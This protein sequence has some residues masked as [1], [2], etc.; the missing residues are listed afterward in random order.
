VLPPIGGAAG[1]AGPAPERRK[2]SKFH[3]GTVKFRMKRELQPLHV[4]RPNTATRC[5][6]PARGR[7]VDKVIARIDADVLPEWLKQ[8]NG[9][10]KDLQAWWGVEGN[11]NGVGLAHFWLS[12][13]S[14]EKRKELLEMEYSLLLT[15]FQAAFQD[16]LDGGFVRKSDI[17]S[18][19]R[20][21]LWEYPEHFGSGDGSGFLDLA[22]ALAS[23]DKRRYRDLLS[24]AKVST[25]SVLYGQWILVLRSFGLISLVTAVTTFYRRLGALG[26]PGVVS[27]PVPAP[28]AAASRR[29][30]T[31]AGGATAGLAR[32]S[33]AVGSRTTDSSLNEAFAAAKMGH[34]DVLYYLLNR[35]VVA[36]DSVDGLGRTLLFVAVAH[37]RTAVASFF[38][39]DNT[40]MFD[41]NAR[42]ASG[43]TALH[44]AVN[45]EDVDMVALLV[46]AGADPDI[47][48]PTTGATPRVLAEMLSL[49]SVLA[50]FD[51]AV[52]APAA[53][54]AEPE[55]MQLP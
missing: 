51:T 14:D 34:A 50:V 53:A 6:T 16:A 7:N 31:A 52:A 41:V 29:P 17:A 3:T 23:E 25:T 37:G 43:N 55:V 42:A 33:T 2:G 32:P 28:A 10:V 45:N 8:A 11:G 22:R 4:P 54:A 12:V 9:A 48:N 15:Q 30:G 38:L 20:G 40:G 44:V 13:F 18:L 39:T 49:K 5:Q 19:L 24:A 21:V 47:P 35:G 27:A 36:S 26:A 46:K 1:P